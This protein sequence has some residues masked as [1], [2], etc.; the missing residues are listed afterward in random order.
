[1]SVKKSSTLI[2]VDN[3]TKKKTFVCNEEEN[4]MAL[5]MKT[6][7]IVDEKGRKK[8]VILEYKDYMKLLDM[9]E[10][11]EDSREI[12]KTMKESEIPLSEYKRKMKSV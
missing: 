3:I 11:Y 7:Y 10:D 1:M 4:L 6:E 9:I 2:I 5:S 8:K 12:R